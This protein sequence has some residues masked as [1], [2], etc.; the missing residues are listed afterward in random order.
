MKREKYIPTYDAT[1]T[2]LPRI[3]ENFKNDPENPFDLKIEVDDECSLHNLRDDEHLDFS[4]VQQDLS[5]NHTRKIT[6][7]VAKKK[8]GV[9]EFIKNSGDTEDLVE[10]AKTWKQVKPQLHTYLDFGQQF[11]YKTSL[12]THAKYRHADIIPY[13]C[14]LCSKYFPRR[15]RLELHILSHTKEKPYICKV[16]SKEFRFKDV[17]LDHQKIHRGETIQCRYC[18]KELTTRQNRRTHERSIHK[19]EYV[20]ENANKSLIRPKVCYNCMFCKNTFL[21]RS[22]FRRHI[23]AHNGDK[24]FE[25]VYLRRF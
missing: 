7:Q 6:I 25:Y 1:V 9:L 3:P 18:P 21:D 11:V 5:T 14:I 12:F 4:R 8:K 2:S 17:L 10:K 23:Q 19:A 20:A 24:P 22:S 16:C 15:R 13:F